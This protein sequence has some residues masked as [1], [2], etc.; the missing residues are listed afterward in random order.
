MITLSKSWL[1]PDRS[2]SEF[3]ISGYRLFRKDRKGNNGGVA[4]YAQ[5]NLVVT[6]RDD[7]KV[8]S[9]EGLWLEIA[10]P[11]SHSFLVGNFYRPN[12]SSK[13]YDEDFLV[14]LNSILDTATANGKEILL[15]SD[16]NCCFISAHHNNSECKQLKSLFKSLNLRQLINSPTRISKDLLTHSLT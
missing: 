12:R 14:K 5:N 7:L 2:D 16:F 1:K 3:K 10:M 11:K 8:D 9:V 6:R 4:V 15:F 13:Y